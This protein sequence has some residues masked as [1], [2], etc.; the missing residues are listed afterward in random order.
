M[1]RQRTETSTPKWFPPPS[2]MSKL[3]VDVALSKNS[4]TASV[5]AVARDG[6]GRF[7]WAST[8]VMYGISETE[9]MEVLA[10][11][12]GMALANDLALH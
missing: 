8:V 9:T 7:L 2:G 4:R 1:V 6:A 5:A 12:E 11:R 10:L 3:D